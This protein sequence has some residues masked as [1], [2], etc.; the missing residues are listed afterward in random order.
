MQDPTI[1][2][3]QYL[4]F[5][6]SWEL[7][8]D[9]NSGEDDVK[10]KGEKYLPMK[11]GTA[12]IEDP[13]SRAKVYDLYRLRA[14]F[15]EVVAP[16]I[17][18]AVGIMLA[19]P[20]KI[21]LPEAMEHLRERATLDGL[22]LD[23]LHRRMGMEVMTTGRYGLLPGLTDDGAPYLSGYVAESI[24]NWDS[25]GGI[26]DYVVLDE[27]GPVRDRDTGQWKDV[28]RLRECIAYDGDYRAR[29]WEQAGAGWTVGDDVEA[30][31]PKG[32][33]L[34]FL[35]FVFVGSL[36]LTPE[37]DDVPLYGL[38]KLAVRIYRLD[39]DFSFSLH[40]TSEPTPVAIGFE[41]PANAIKQGLAP[42]TLGS[43]VLWI[44]PQGGDAKYLE[45]SG[46]GLEKQ[47]N[48]IQEALARAAQFGAQVIQSGQSVESGEALKL[49]AA[50]Q[51]ATLTSIA[52]TTAAGLERS[53]RNI[54]KW[55]GADPEQVIVTPNLEFFD[56]AIT[57]QDIQALVAAW[58]SGA[59]SHRALFD[60]LQQGGVIHE[61]KSYKDEEKDIDADDVDGDPLAGAGL[62][63]P[64]TEGATQ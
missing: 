9:A 33:A 39:A 2:H 30:R 40:M 22:T 42:K 47:A 58:Q 51:T 54:A 62:I 44:L 52:Q 36:D 16:T 27:S 63:F 12:A 53:L 11:T 55:I 1:K 17:R 10:A 7:M 21:E 4:S 29:V 41:D 64:G 15:P 35:P 49:R 46:P 23:A 28:T 25:T 3:P 24:I 19:K 57:A 34:D 37:P 50:S 14:E 8:R 20:A 6:P 60:K 45:F 48:A 59:M 43:S 31:T 56:R 5:A 32:E 61:D 13:T 26:P 18:G 38:A